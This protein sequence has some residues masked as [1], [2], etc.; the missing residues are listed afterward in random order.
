[1]TKLYIPRSALIPGW[2]ILN[3]NIP[4]DAKTFFGVL[5]G[6]S[7]SE[8]R[9]HGSVFGSDKT[10]AE[11][12]K[13]SVRTIQRWLDSLEKER[14]IRRDTRTIPRENKDPSKDK[15]FEWTKDRKIY[16]SDDISNISSDTATSVENDS[17]ISYDTDRSG[18]FNEHDRNGGFNEHDKSGGYKQRSLKSK[19][20]KNNKESMSHTEKKV[21]K[22]KKAKDFLTQPE[23]KKYFDRLMKFVPAE[24][25]RLDEES[26]SW[27]IKHY[28][29]ARVK[30]A[31]LIYN[32]Q[33]EKHYKNSKV[34]LPGKMG[35]YVCW[36]LKE[37]IQPED[38]DFMKNKN[39]ATEISKKH[40][41]I[42][43]K[44]KY[45]KIRAATLRDEML[46]TAPVETFKR[47]ILEKI[48]TAL[49]YAC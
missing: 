30:T 23:E 42:E 37:N 46:F 21:K 9:T 19:V 14:A 16:I 48:E 22:A 18:G 35:A 24:G 4:G 8:G 34:P 27:W 13:V 20:L 47:W 33:V 29:I 38:E 43:V 5:N 31:V 39:F 36:A 40:Q 2:M 26:V 17:N 3:K 15:E 10:F 41:F 49:A 6:L 1:M 25:A 44:E 28:G 11:L 7:K 45:V 12:M 32:L